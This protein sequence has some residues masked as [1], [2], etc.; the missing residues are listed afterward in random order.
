MTHSVRRIG[1][2]IAVTA[3][4]LA[5]L[6][7]TAAQTGPGASTGTV[8]HAD[9]VWRVAVPAPDN[10]PNQAAPANEPNQDAPVD[11]TTD[12]PDITPQDSVW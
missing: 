4:A 6:A 3:A 5:A 8:T 9:S 1:A 10:E 2:L 12:Q 11:G 7:V